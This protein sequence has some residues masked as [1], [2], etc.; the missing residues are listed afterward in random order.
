MRDQRNNERN[1]QRSDMDRSRRD[2]SYSR[3]GF[4]GD[5]YRSDDLRFETDSY[6]NR[7]ERDRRNFGRWNDRDREFNG[8]GDRSYGQQGEYRSRDSRLDEP[9]RPSS[10]SRRQGRSFEDDGTAGLYGSGTS[11]YQS[12]GAM[13]TSSWQ[14]SSYGT[15]DSSSRMN[16]LG[17]GPKG[18]KR[19]DERIREDVCERLERDA[20]VDA[21]E[22]EVSVR[23]GVVTLSGKVEDRPSKRQA[24]DIIE[25]L[26]G[27]KDVRNDLT[28][29]QS[30]FGQA[31]DMIMGKSETDKAGSAKAGGKT[32]PH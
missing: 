19:S 6:D 11:D 16:H 18:W 2:R 21:S 3:S 26:P 8:G 13:G 20:R 24:E 27:V 7:G 17:K 22:I 23:D 25:F 10:S 12:L 31:K 4:S 28:V 32:A 14:G 1:E 9:F 15:R 30:L 5:E 29:D